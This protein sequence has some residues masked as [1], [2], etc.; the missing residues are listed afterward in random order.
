M[1]FTQYSVDDFAFNESFQAYVARPESEA[2]R[3]W[4]AWLRQ[5]P[6]KQAAAAQAAAFVRRLSATR[7]Y[8]VPP[9]LVGQELLRLRQALRAPASQ[10]QLRAQRRAWRVAGAFGLLTALLVGALLGWWRGA[11][12]AA[13]T[14]RLAHYT[15]GA[16]QQ[17]RLT[18]PDGS[19]VTLNANSTLTTAATW[20][21]AAPREVWLSGEG[22]FEVT[23]LATKPVADIGAAPANVKFV[24]HA[25][26]LR[27]AV[28]GTQFDVNTRAG[29]T[30]V[31]L[32]SGKVAVD[33]PAGLAPE[34]VL[35]TPGDLV[36][37]SSARPGLRQR[38]VQPALYAGWTQG[39]LRFE[40]TPVPEVMQLLRD[41]YGLRVEVADSAI[42]R[43]T[44]YGVVP[45]T[46][47]D[48]L[49]AALA[50]TLNVQVVRR[51][52][53]VRFVPARP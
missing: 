40:Q 35:M 15:T 12:P 51:G 21:A 25:G 24:V 30:R 9:E 19:V 31:V 29:T 18:L 43:K 45:T 1:D 11:Q 6:E 41:S 14:G 37:T 36:E 49:L 23:H 27:V 22:Y 7:P 17:K 13:I 8:P 39:R 2:G 32:T 10:P 50:K 26:G 28:L 33:R 47:P 3:F 16:R 42:L 34:K 48:V 38:R 44:V 20:T 46:T 4:Q 5:H 53:T 52:N